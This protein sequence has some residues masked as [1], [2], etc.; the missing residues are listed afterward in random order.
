MPLET[1]PEAHFIL[2]GSPVL[3]WSPAFQSAFG[4]LTLELVKPR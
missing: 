1:L 2:R 3:P 4:S